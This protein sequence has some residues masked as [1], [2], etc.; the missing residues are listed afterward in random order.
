MEKRPA[1]C[2]LMLEKRDAGYLM[3]L[4]RGKEII[5]RI[6]DCLGLVNDP[7]LNGDKASFELTEEQFEAI[8][9]RTFA[10]RSEEAA[11]VNA[12]CNIPHLFVYNDTMAGV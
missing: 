11:A 8:S 4:L 3:T 12:Q 2:R 1:R 7:L 10:L 6:E 9:R 5:L